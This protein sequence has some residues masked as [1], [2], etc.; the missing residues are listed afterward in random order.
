MPYLRT[1]ER[2]YFYKVVE[3]LKNHAISSPGELNYL[4]TEIINQ[5]FM[6]H[7]KNYHTIN[8][9]VGALES[10]KLEF[11]RRVAGPYEEKKIAENGEV[12]DQEAL[13]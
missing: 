1:M 4:F 12:Y 13:L 5:Y 9:I 10:C 7:T 11:Y 2:I 8:D 6:N 3:S